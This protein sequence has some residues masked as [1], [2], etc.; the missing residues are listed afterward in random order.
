ML[1]CSRLRAKPNEGLFAKYRRK[2]CERGNRTL[3][4]LLAAIL[5]TS[6]AHARTLDLNRLR[7]QPRF[8]P[9]PAP[10]SHLPGPYQAI[11]RRP[12]SNMGDLA[13]T[14]QVAALTTVA[15]SDS[16]LC[17]TACRGSS[18]LPSCGARLQP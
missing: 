3:G 13:K 8:H 11:Q 6:S 9:G 4:F 5:S 14:R 1:R 12:G 17:D 15:G 16:F 18:L 7:H 2:D 10:T